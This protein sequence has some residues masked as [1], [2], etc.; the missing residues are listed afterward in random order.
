MW[1][2][3]K[4]KLCNEFG[5]FEDGQLIK[6]LGVRYEWKIF[7][8]GEIYMVVSINDKSEEIIKKYE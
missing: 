4:K 2:K 8:S 3:L 7:K 1:K 5:I 6:L